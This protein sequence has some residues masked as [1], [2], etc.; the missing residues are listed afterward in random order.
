[1]KW[2]MFL[3]LVMFVGFSI[4]TIVL[5]DMGNMGWALFCAIHAVSYIVVLFGVMILEK[6][7]AAIKNTEG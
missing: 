1:M 3:C 6:I 2:I 5:G 7:E 4:A